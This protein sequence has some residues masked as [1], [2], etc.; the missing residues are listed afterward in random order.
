MRL[1]CRDA[2]E[3][4]NACP[5]LMAGVRARH[6]QSEPK[7]AFLGGFA[8]AHVHVSRDLRRPSA[9]A[10]GASLAQQCEAHHQHKRAGQDKC[11]RPFN[12]RIMHVALQGRP[13]ALA[14]PAIQQSGAR[15]INDQPPS[16][17][18]PTFP[19]SSSNHA[20]YHR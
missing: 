5:F 16:L 1:R 12:A 7:F 6:L 17:Y 3:G 14:A 9:S 20:R 11:M 18:L 8:F 13:V 10:C 19:I 2:V 4:G 15:L